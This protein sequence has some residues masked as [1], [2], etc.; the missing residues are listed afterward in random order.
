VY[1]R[2]IVNRTKIVKVAVHH[3]DLKNRGKTVTANQNRGKTATIVM[4][5]KLMEGA[6]IMLVMISTQVN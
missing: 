5:R 1:K 3:L 6:I 4:A 2:Q